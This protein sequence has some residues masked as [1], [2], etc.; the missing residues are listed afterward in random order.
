MDHEYLHARG[1]SFFSV[2]SDIFDIKCNYS[3]ELIITRIYSHL[4]G[5]HTS[6]QHEQNL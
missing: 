5:L 2:Y 1:K 4:N 6:L 3:N